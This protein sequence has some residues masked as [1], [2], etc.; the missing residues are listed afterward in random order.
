MIVFKSTVK[1]EQM[2]V[3]AVIHTVVFPER[4][5]EVFQEQRLYIDYTREHYVN[6]PAST[7]LMDSNG[8]LNIMKDKSG[9]QNYVAP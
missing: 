9:L 5:L 4:K 8:L 2:L 3:S 6:G 7:S 1:M